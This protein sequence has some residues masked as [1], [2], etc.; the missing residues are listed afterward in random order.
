MVSG[1]MVMVHGSSCCSVVCQCDMN[2]HLM[3]CMTCLVLMTKIT[4]VIHGFYL[5][6]V[7]FVDFMSKETMP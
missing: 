4:F 5:S 6:G 7:G 2:S 3:F 1:N